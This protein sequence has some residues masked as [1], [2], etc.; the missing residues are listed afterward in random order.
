[1]S[2]TKIKKFYATDVMTVEMSVA[3]TD[4]RSHAVFVRVA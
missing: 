3:D 1:M 2:V 4:V